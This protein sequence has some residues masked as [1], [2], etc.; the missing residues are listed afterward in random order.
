MKILKTNKKSIFG[1]LQQKKDQL[2]RYKKLTEKWIGDKKPKPP[3]SSA[4]T[5]LL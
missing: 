2:G 5:G 3:Q 4:T 1:L